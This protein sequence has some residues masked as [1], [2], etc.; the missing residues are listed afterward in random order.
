MDALERAKLNCISLWTSRGA[1]YFEVRP[2]GVQLGALT[3]KVNPEVGM[4][5]A[6]GERVLQLWF[7]PEIP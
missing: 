2:V 4:L 1:S 6:D 5:T 3:V 7:K